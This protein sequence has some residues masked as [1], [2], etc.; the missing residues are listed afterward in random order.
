[1]AHAMITRQRKRDEYG[2]GASVFLLE[3]TFYSLF[4]HLMRFI[5]HLIKKF[6]INLI[7]PIYILGISRYIIVYEREEKHGWTFNKKKRITGGEQSDDTNCA[8]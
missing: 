2:P 6:S 8:Q 5:R 1:M 7:K 3:C 4:Y